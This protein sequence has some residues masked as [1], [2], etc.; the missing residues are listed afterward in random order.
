MTKIKGF[1]IWDKKKKEFVRFR[2][3]SYLAI[4]YENDEVTLQ[5]PKRYSLKVIK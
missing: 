1:R 4:T 3:F 2:K 5:N